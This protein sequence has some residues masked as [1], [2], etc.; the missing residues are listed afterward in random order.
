MPISAASTGHSMLGR[1][2]RLPRCDLLKSGSY[3]YNG[4]GID[5]IEPVPAIL[6]GTTFTP[7]S[8]RASRH[9]SVTLAS[10]RADV[11]RNRE[12]ASLKS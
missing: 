12:V 7:L 3:D 6:P 5:D 2:R 11:D 9:S 1:G 8:G 4:R 10:R